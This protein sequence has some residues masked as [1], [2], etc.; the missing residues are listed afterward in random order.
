MDRL[1]MGA[2]QAV[3]AR[4]LGE[5]GSTPGRRLAPSALQRLQRGGVPRAMQP[6]S[7]HAANLGKSDTFRCD[8]HHDPRQARLRLAQLQRV[9]P[10]ALS[11]E[12]LGKLAESVGLGDLDRI[13]AELRAQS[14]VDDEPLDQ[15]REL[16]GLL[17]SG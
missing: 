15:L 10:V 1:P 5:S 13:P 11:S 16:F 17:V 6:V 7:E 12:L 14:G 9:D 4:R 2:R 8:R 3:K